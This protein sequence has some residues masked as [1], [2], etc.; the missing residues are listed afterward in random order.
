ME[1]LGQLYADA[2]ENFLTTLP[3]LEQ[4]PRREAGPLG[5]Y[6]GPA[7]RRRAEPRWPDAPGK[8]VFAYVK[9]FDG[10]AIQRRPAAK[11]VATLLYLDGPADAAKEYESDT[12]R[13]GG[14]GRTSRG[15][16]GSATRRCC[17]RDRG[18]PRRRSWRASRC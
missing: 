2:D 12:V 13:V 7:L 18:R 4:H 11:R 9:K 17:T 10:L 1:R 15:W 5:F 6:W 14:S 16:P 3:E 8:R